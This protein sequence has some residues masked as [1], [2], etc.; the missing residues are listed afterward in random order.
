MS[1]LRTS[2]P[3]STIFTRAIPSC[4]HMKHFKSQPTE[5]HSLFHHPHL[6]ESIILIFGQVAHARTPQS[7]QS[8]SSSLTVRLDRPHFL[9]RRIKLTNRWSEVSAG[10]WDR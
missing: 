1:L 2:S 9:T 5:E 4:R 8:H 6:A 7:K 10:Q 3:S